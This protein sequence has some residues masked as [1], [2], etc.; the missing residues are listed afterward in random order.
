T[1]VV[2]ATLAGAV[3]FVV[4]WLLDVSILTADRSSDDDDDIRERAPKRQRAASKTILVFGLRIVLI[5]GS[6]AVT[7]PF[8]SMFVFRDDISQTIWADAQRSIHAAREAMVTEQRRA[9]VDAG[10]AVSVKRRELENEVAGY[11]RSRRYGIGPVVQTLQ[12]SVKE[13]GDRQSDLKT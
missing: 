1:A 12:Q 9:E 7:A 11:G 8:L 2:T 4:V 5:V 6:V 3:M 13:L 10:S